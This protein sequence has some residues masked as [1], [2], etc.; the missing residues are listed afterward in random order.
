MSRT[1]A[2]A[3][4]GPVRRL[5]EPLALL[6]LFALTMAGCLTSVL[7]TDSPRSLWPGAALAAAGCAVLTW[8]RRH[9][10]RILAVTTAFTLA[11]GGLGY[12]LTPLLMG[13]VLLAMYDLSLRSSRSTAR[14]A[15]LVVATLTAVVGLLMQPP[16]Q[17]L[18]LG[19][20]NSTAWV[21]LAALTG[22][23]TG[24][25]RTLAAERAE[26]EERARQEEVWR[27]V[28]QERMRIARELHD[29][30][31]HHLALANAQAGTATHL[32]RSHPEATYEM[33]RTLSQTTATALR[34]MKSTVRLL[35]QDS[36]PLAENA[37][38]PG[39]AQL[40]DL[41]AALAT[42]GLSVTLTLDGEQRAL[43]AG[44]DLTAYR[45]V[46]E[47]LT[48]VTKH[49]ATSRTDVHLAYRP[50]SLTITVTNDT[51]PSRQPTRVPAEP[52]QGFGLIGM[53]E[54][55]QSAGGTLSA[56]PRPEGGFRV[57]ATLPL[58]PS[59]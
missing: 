2:A 15:S 42:A 52:T 36:D 16:G 20:V 39:L 18:V 37:P 27:H 43:A 23:Y 55:A 46:Q 38:A 47:A 53:R 14:V 28:I 21:L 33:L 13:P 6:G 26:Q 10:L 41:I 11:A 22:S 1:G 29:A 54:R 49:A 32:F 57:T 56:G 17:P 24:V 35:R 30:V 51:P 5:S 9:P 50:G 34:E 40:D 44:A 3:P 8:R 45:I 7:V 31:A 25:R 59:I 12:L 4:P 48:N 58:G 19:V